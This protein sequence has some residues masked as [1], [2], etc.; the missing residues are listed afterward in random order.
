[1]REM[2][3]KYYRNAK[4]ELQNYIGEGKGS[5]DPFRKFGKQPRESSFLALCP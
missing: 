3:I 2:Q 4:S 5:H 1:M